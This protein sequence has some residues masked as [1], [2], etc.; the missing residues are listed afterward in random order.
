VYLRKKY[1]PRLKTLA[2]KTQNAAFVLMQNTGGENHFL[3]KIAINSNYKLTQIKSFPKSKV[4]F[5]RQINFSA[6]GKKFWSMFV[7]RLNMVPKVGREL[8]FFSSKFV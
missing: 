5:N 1:L 7:K 8:T 3:L 4:I 6:P 2:L